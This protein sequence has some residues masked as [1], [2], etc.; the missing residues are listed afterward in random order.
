VAPCIAGYRRLRHTLGWRPASQTQRNGMA[1]VGAFKPPSPATPNAPLCSRRRCTQLWPT[2]LRTNNT[3]RG[4]R[5][6]SSRPR[7]P[8]SNERTLSQIPLFGRI[9]GRG[10]R[11]PLL[12]CAGQLARQRDHTPCHALL[13]QQSCV[14][15]MLHLCSMMPGVSQEQALPVTLTCL[16]LPWPPQQGLPR[17]RFHVTSSTLPSPYGT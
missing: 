13:E 16:C 2:H 3:H 7:W 11:H 9:R 17:A 4:H 12:A 6:A 10:S 8:P 5:P 15:K 14:M 1:R